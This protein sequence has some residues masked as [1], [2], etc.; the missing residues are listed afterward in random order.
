MAIDTRREQL[1]LSW[2][3]GNELVVSLDPLQGHWTEEQYLL[4]TDQTN[5]LLE[6]TDGYIE[7]L[8]MPTDNHQAMLEWLFLALKAFIERLGGKVRFAPLRVLVREGKYREPDILLVRDAR[9]PRRQNRFWLG[10]D[11]VAEIVS[12]DDPERD[13]KVKRADYAYAGIPEYWIVN[14]FEQT[15]TVLAL[16]D[17]TYTEYG[18][19][20]RGEQAASKLL[21]GFSIRVDGVFDAE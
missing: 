14:P 21:E 17:E 11:L 4:L 8:P 7:V 2:E 3:K 5:R 9:D 10:A 12:E 1:R 18:V 15:I 16:K 19:F 6:Y 13:T 20:R